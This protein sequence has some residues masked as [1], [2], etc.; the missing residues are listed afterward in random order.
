MIYMYQACK[1]LLRLVFPSPAP[2]FPGARSSVHWATKRVLME[3]E[4]GESGGICCGTC[5][6][7]MITLIA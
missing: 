2:A 3:E 7:H 5:W 4:E 1:T 6:Y